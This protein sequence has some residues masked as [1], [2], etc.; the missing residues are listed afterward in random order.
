MTNDYMEWGEAYLRDAQMLREKL[1]RIQAGH[2]WGASEAEWKRM[3]TLYEMYMEC[4]AVGH[5]LQ[6]RAGR[7]PVA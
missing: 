5:M 3:R 6:R 4:T 1:D 7:P 2:R